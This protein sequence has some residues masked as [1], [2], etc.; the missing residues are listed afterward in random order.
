MH[1]SQTIINNKIEEEFASLLEKSL[2]REQYSCSVMFI[3]QEHK[4]YENSFN[5]SSMSVQ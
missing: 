3:L 2:Q 4:S 1:A 5:I